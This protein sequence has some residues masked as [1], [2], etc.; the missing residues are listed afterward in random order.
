MKKIGLLFVLLL[1]FSSMFA[2]LKVINQQQLKVTS[3]HKECSIISLG[4][5]GFVVYE[6]KK[7]SDDLIKILF[8]SFNSKLEKVWDKEV[9]FDEDM[10]TY[11]IGSDHDGIYLIAYN[12]VS[13]TILNDKADEFMM[14]N[15]SND[16]ELSQKKIKFDKKIELYKGVFINNACY[17]DVFMEKKGYMLKFDFSSMSMSKNIFKIPENTVIPD[18]FSFGNTLYFRVR[19]LKKSINYDALYSIEDGVVVDK[20]LMERTDEDDIEKVNVIET[21]SLH[22]FVLI[23]KMDSR[24]GSL[25]PDENPERQCYIANM[26]NFSKGVIHKVD[27]ATSDVFTKDRGVKIQNGPLANTFTGKYKLYKGKYLL[28]SSIRVQDKNIFVFE[29]YQEMYLENSNSYTTVGYLFTNVIVW[30]VNDEGVLEW[31]KNYECENI[32]PFE[33]SKISAKPHIDN[34]FVL[35]GFF[36]SDYSYKIISEKGAVIKDTQEEKTVTNAKTLQ[37]ELVGYNTLKLNKGTFL[38]WSIIQNNKKEKKQDLDLELM[39]IEIK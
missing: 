26:D 9:S 16:G 6:E 34:S 14:V 18:R 23:T 2:Q 12:S 29:K 39:S 22:Q 25:M 33:K 13:M 3:S 21:D 11:L 4:E 32:S 20:V 15:I 10:Y 28:S 19:S 38:I 37:T 36:N 24:F 31:S 1:T 30:C 7:T 8:T 27:K 35:F 5:N 17:F